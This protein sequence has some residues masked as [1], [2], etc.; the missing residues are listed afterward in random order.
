MLVEEIIQNI[1]QSHADGISY[2]EWNAGYE[3]DSNMSSDGFTIHMNVDEE[4][5][6]I[7]GGNA[8][9]CLTWMDKMGS[10][11]RAGNK[12]FPATPRAGAPV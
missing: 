5:G 3:I 6:F 8:F 10:S 2:R 7:I 11:A 9:N 12:G 4:T 1:F